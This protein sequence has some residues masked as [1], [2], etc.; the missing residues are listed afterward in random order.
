MGAPFDGMVTAVHVQPG[1]WGA[2]GL[3]V[4]ELVGDGELEVVIGSNSSHFWLVEADGTVM[5]GWPRG[6]INVG[7]FS[8]SPVLADIVGD[9][10]LEVILVGATGWV[11][12]LDYLGNTLP[13]WPQSLGANT[14]AS[15]AV[16]DVDDDPEMEIVVGCESGEIYA[17]DA[18]GQILDGWPIRM[19]RASQPQG[20]A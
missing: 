17:F 8:P 9:D 16:A 14:Y 4:A 3:P 18:D 6:T 10:C 7:D 1:E 5:D 12:A 15:P 20:V 13:G 11:L 19:E 2:P